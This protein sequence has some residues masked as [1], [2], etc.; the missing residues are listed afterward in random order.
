MKSKE[1]AQKLLAECG[2]TLDGGK[3]WDIR[4]HDERLY[5]RVFAG[6]SLAAGE[7]YMDGWWDVEDLAG[8]FFHV[9]RAVPHD[10]LNVGNAWQVLKSK[11][12]NLQSAARAFQVGK[13]H[14]DVGNDLYRRMLGERMIYSCGYWKDAE[15]L[16]EAQE[17][18]LELICRKIGLKA[19]DT[20]LD[21]GCGWGGFAKFAAE[22]YGARVVGLTVS[23]EQAAYAREY[24][25]GLPVE[26]RLQDWRSLGGE[27]FSHVVS[28]GMFEHVGPKNYRA[29]MKKVHEV[30]ADDGLFLLHTIGH[31]RSMNSLEPWFDRYIFPNGHLPSVGQITAAVDAA[32]PHEPLFML[33]D[34]HNF[35]AHYDTTLCAWAERFEEAWP[36]LAGAYDERFHR[37]WRYYLLV[38]AGMFRAR[39]IHLWQI[40]FSKKGVVGGYESVR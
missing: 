22:K 36:D 34:W 37:M 26:I 19:G 5:D 25:K 33:E 14:Y 38:S 7:S 24:T 9:F 11:V 4:V 39:Y 17:A 8:F 15:S 30:L 40:V 10:M 16:D 12:L 2:I 13:K 20:V 18:K 28:V 1:R 35:G 3:P 27:T 6:G 23:A 32:W 21:I 31:S 29:F